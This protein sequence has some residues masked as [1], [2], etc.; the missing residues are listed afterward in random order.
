MRKCEFTIR[1]PQ[2]NN[3]RINLPE[4]LDQDFRKFC[5]LAPA[6]VIR[7]LY[8]IDGQAGEERIVFYHRPSGGE[9]DRTRLQLNEVI[10]ANVEA[11]N[12]LTVMSIRSTTC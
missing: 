12:E 6:I 8:N 2:R 9:F 7:A 3:L 5:G 4:K 11:T 10:E 1:L